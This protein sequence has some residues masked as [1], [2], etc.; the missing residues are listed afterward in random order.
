MKILIAEDDAG[1]RSLLNHKLSSWGFDVVLAVDGDEAWD[2]LQRNDGPKLILLDWMMPGMNGIEI[3]L[4]I[5]REMTSI[6]TYLIFL[7]GRVD[8]KDIVEGLEAGADDYITKPFEDSELRARINAGR[9]IIE[10]QSALLEKERLD[11]VVEIA[12]AVCHELSQPLQAISGISELLL[13][14]I[15]N[16]GPLYGKIE[17]VRE[18]TERMGT[19]IQKLMQI[20][21]Y[22]T[23]DLLKTKVIDTDKASDEAV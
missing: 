8:K 15:E 16:K 11:G 7:T 9:R 18:Q 23:K 1:T 12:R 17:K 4:R 20:T 21:P 19:I 10:L 22:K 14:E 13:M 3:C 2:V 5:R 6:P